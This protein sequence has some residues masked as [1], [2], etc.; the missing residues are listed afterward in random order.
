MFN[1]AR[2]LKLS[3]NNLLGDTSF[4]LSRHPHCLTPKPRA[5]DDDR[6]NRKPLSDLGRTLKS[7]NKTAARVCPSFFCRRQLLQC[8]IN[9]PILNV[10]SVNVASC[11]PLLK[12]RYTDSALKRTEKTPTSKVPIASRHF[13]PYFCLIYTCCRF[14]SSAASCGPRDKQER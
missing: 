10:I 12:P 13:S 6:R 11:F 8:T 1:K 5:V 14:R 7:P 4:L 9:K 3:P 2:R